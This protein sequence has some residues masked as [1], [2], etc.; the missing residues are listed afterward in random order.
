MTEDTGSSISFYTPDADDKDASGALVAFSDCE[1]IEINLEMVMVINRQNGNQLIISPQVA[2][3]LKTCTTFKTI[4]AH[5]QHLTNT[6][7]ELKGQESM[8]VSA[9]EQLDTAGILLHASD[10][11]ARLAQ[12]SARELPPTRVF[13]TTC[14]RPAALERLLQSMRQV[15]ELAQHDNLFVVD[16]SRDSENRD[17]NRELV[18]GFNR[19]SAREIHYIGVS[20]QQALIEGLIVRLPECERDIRFLLD[21]QVWQDFATFGRA[22]NV[23]LM[24]SVGYRT[25]MIDDDVLLESILSPIAEKGVSVG[26]RGV[27]QAGFFESKDEM[28]SAVKRADFDPLSGHAR[29][30]GS[31]L[32]SALKELNEGGLAA[33]QLQ[34]CS[35]LIANAFEPESPILVTQN[36]TL[37]DPGTGSVHWGITLDDAS[38]RRLAQEPQ[39]V[40]AAL[41]N[42]LVWLGCTRANFFKLSVISQ[43]AGLDNSY[44]LPPYFPVFRGED[45]LF[46][47]MLL[48]VQPNGAVLEYPWGVPHLPLDERSFSVDDAFVSG[49][50]LGQVSEWIISSVDPQS[51]ATPEQNLSRLSL[52]LERVSVRSDERLRLDFR[53][54]LARS[55]AAL[56]GLYADRCFMAEELK[57]PELQELLDRGLKEYNQ[58]LASPSS[59]LEIDGIPEAMTEAEFFSQF[60][61]MAHGFAGALAS[62][63]AVRDV[64]TEVSQ[65]LVN[66]REMIPL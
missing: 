64:A 10:I 25:L 51:G 14:D 12:E 30:L 62:W 28:F 42:R 4:A 60:R 26:A 36:G 65:D 2:E 37:G 53:A 20:E 15:K 38:L 19:T 44:L 11:S 27:R 41:E 39:G 6:R 59:P 18:G 50:H 23:C 8:A 61:E 40:R 7:P 9:L 43:I 16:D 56:L 66:S 57:S 31:H 24:F 49:G 29:F 33:E 45:M 46:G 35:A 63:P 3:G 58:T 17:A 54:S 5:A 48:S 52:E 13:I 34:D 55:H 32:S 21:A 47:A 1:I 22:R